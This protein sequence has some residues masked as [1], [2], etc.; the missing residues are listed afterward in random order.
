M[1]ICVYFTMK[2]KAVGSKQESEVDLI[3]LASKASLI[4]KP[5][6]AET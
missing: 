4:A 1:V 6:Q 2:R 3:S 5:T